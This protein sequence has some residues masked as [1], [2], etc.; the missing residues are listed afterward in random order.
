MSEIMFSLPF[1]TQSEFYVYRELNSLFFFE[2]VHLL[3][4]HSRLLTLFLPLKTCCIPEH[5]PIIGQQYGA[6]LLSLLFMEFQFYV[7]DED[8]DR[9]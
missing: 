6:Y 3:V 7:T 9:T 8:L 1:L 4:K 2:D 5:K